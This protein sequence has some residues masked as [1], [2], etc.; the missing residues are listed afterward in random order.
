MAAFID[1]AQRRGA[2]GALTHRRVEPG[3]PSCGWPIRSTVFG[4]WGAARALPGPVFAVTGSSGKTTVR[5]FLNAALDCPQATGSLNNFWGMPLSLART[6]RDAPAR[7]WRIGT[8]HPGEIEPLAKLVSP[9]C[10]ARAQR[11]ARH[12][13][14]F[15]SIE[16]LRAEKTSIFNGLVDGGVAYP[17]RSRVPPPAH[18]HSHEDFP[19]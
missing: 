7:C 6:P 11:T 13:Q 14:Y 17:R 3:C 1:D 9:H 19:G 8:N 4:R 12:L 5:S 16:T 18:R 10:C 15:G 2:I